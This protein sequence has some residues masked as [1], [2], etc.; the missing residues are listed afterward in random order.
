MLLW[1]CVVSHLFEGL[2]IWS[3]SQQGLSFIVESLYTSAVE[4]GLVRRPGV[5]LSENIDPEFLHLVLL[6]K[7]L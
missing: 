5:Y 6:V 2:N 1:E 4:S 7:L 3:P